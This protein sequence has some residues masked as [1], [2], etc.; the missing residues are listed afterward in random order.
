[1]TKKRPKK[2][3]P[4]KERSVK[5]PRRKPSSPTVLRDL[6]R[7]PLLELPSELHL[8]I[9]DY[10]T[11]K[12]KIHL[13]Q[14]RNTCR[15]FRQII[16]VESKALTLRLP[17]QQAE[18]MKKV[19]QA[20]QRGWEPGDVRLIR[21]VIE[22]PSPSLSMTGQL[23]ARNCFWFMCQGCE[24]FYPEATFFEPF[25]RGRFWCDSCIAQRGIDRWA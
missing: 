23:V 6:T 12:S 20:F 16:T 22:R 8:Q 3:P 24:M 1:M 4:P 11:A 19:L 25:V 5:K 18:E 13:I 15:H 7:T 21:T 10:L 9:I 17:P 2:N 14:L